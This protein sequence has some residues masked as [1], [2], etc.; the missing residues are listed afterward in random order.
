LHGALALLTRVTRKAP[1]F[2]LRGTTVPVITLALSS[3]DEAVLEADIAAKVGE[4]GDSLVGGL[5]V[6]DLSALGDTPP[7]LTWLVAQVRRFGLIPVG[8]IGARDE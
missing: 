5:A 1:S 7:R 6:I 3:A 4:A 8:V 2:R